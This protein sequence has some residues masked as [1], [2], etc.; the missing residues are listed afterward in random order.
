MKNKI[1]I[2]L[3]TLGLITVSSLGLVSTLSCIDDTTTQQLQ[4]KELSDFIKSENVNNYN[5][6]VK[7]TTYNVDR[8]TNRINLVLF[9]KLIN[10][11]NGNQLLLIA[12]SSATAIIDLNTGL[13]LEIRLKELPLKCKNFNLIYGGRLGVL[14]VLDNTRYSTIDSNKPK[15]YDNKDLLKNVL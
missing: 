14:K 13:T 15:I 12:F 11:I 6:L 8:I 3:G 7:S 9:T 10:D 4:T 1:K 2:I 5:L